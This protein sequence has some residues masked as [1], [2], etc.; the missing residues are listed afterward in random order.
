MAAD[1][2][3][4]LTLNACEDLGLDCDTPLVELAEQHALVRSFLAMRSQDVDGQETTQLPRSKQVVFNLHGG[5]WRGLTWWD[6]AAGVVWLLG[7]GYHRSGASDDV[8]ELLKAR[9]KAGGLF[10]SEEDYLTLEP[11]KATAEAFATDVMDRGPDVAEAAVKSPDTEIRTVFG[12]I[13]EVRVNSTKDGLWIGFLQPPLVSGVL[14]GG[15]Y[16]AVVAALAPSAEIDDL[17]F[18]PGPFPG[19]PHTSHEDVVLV[20]R[21]ALSP[22]ESAD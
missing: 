3:L 12:G 6:A 2:D 8:Y 7:A 5:R 11:T 14:P 22:V 15:Y 4:R 21:S 20:A 1:Y 13:L 10:P 18:S 9:D 16:L 17:D 19:A